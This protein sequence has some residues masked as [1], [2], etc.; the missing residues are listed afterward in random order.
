M[1]P[2]GILQNDSVRRRADN[3]FERFEF[4]D[5]SGDSAHLFLSED[6][7]SS[8]V[9]LQRRHSYLHVL[10]LDRFACVI[11]H[12]VGSTDARG[13][14]NILVHHDLEQRRDRRACR[15]LKPG[16]RLR[17]RGA[18]APG[19]R[20]PRTREPSSSG[21]ASACQSQLTLRLLR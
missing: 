1:R 4:A 11:E 20:L 15:L 9:S 13:G 21:A 17:E 7:A 16:S 6:L 12:G 5:P 3:P 2:S 14:L 19:D 8:A 10:D 18:P